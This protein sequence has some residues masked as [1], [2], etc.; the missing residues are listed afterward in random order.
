MASCHVIREAPADT[1]VTLK[2]ITEKAETA[3]E[4]LH[5]NVLK[6]ANVSS[7][8]E[9]TTLVRTQSELYADKLKTLASQVTEEVKNNFHFQ[10]FPRI[11]KIIK[12]IGQS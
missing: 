11:N 10:S 5:E 7:D 9:L 1:T 4:T 12:F 6:F 8:A 3:Y 2:D